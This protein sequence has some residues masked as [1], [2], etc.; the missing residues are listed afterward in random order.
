MNLKIIGEN[1][2]RIYN[3]YTI[4]VYRASFALA[5][6]SGSVDMALEIDVFGR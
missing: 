5:F 4:S 1:S 2:G 6:V 3:E